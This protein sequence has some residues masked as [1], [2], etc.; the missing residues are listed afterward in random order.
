MALTNVMKK[1]SVVMGISF[2]HNPSRGAKYRSCISRSRLKIP[3]APRSKVA[4]R[5]TPSPR[6]RAGARQHL[7]ATTFL[8][9]FV[10]QGF[11]RGVPDL[12]HARGIHVVR[13][14]TRIA[15]RLSRSRQ[16]T[17]HNRFTTEDKGDTN[18]VRGRIRPG[19]KPLERKG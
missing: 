13:I 19:T 11:L 17:L 3:F 4:A 16:R 15:P 2:P 1:N 12:V 18:R 6:P 10:L 5:T 14:T 7:L 8:A 9:S